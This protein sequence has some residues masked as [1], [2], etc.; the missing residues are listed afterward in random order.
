[1]NPIKDEMMMAD[2]T[3]VITRTFFI[4]NLLLVGIELDSNLFYRI[5]QEKNKEKNKKINKYLSI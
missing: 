2:D 1:V 5:L 3:A 4:S